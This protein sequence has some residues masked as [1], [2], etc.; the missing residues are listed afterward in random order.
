MFDNTLE[1][2]EVWVKKPKSGQAECR[3]FIKTNQVDEAGEVQYIRP[4][5]PSL[6]QLTRAW[7]VHN[8]PRH[9]VEYH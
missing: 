7:H 5:G 3:Y 4:V 8:F 2:D 6:L 1:C 9:Q